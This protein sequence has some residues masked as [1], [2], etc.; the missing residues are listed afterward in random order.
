MRSFVDI[1][2]IVLLYYIYHLRWSSCIAY[3]IPFIDLD[4]LSRLFDELARNTASTPLVRPKP[5]CGLGDMFFRGNIRNRI[6]AKTLH[7]WTEK[8][9]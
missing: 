2:H 7:F 9:D 5:F 8:E 3:D 6:E 4:H 1:E